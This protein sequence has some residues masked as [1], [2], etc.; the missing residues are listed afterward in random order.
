MQKQAA[1]LAFGWEKSYEEI[2]AQHNITTLKKRREI[3][4]DKFVVKNVNNPRFGLEWFP[5]RHSDNYNIRDRDPFKE[6]KCRTTRYYN[7]PLSFMRRRANAL[8]QA[9]DI[10]VS[11]N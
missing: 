2:C 9:G 8:V 7:S 3:Q 6:T 4:I 11:Y 5:T 1:K 10:A